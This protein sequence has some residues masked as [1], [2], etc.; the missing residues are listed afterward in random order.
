MS[1]SLNPRPVTERGSRSLATLDLPHRAIETASMRFRERTVDP[2]RQ[3]D[4]DSRPMVER[5]QLVR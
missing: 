4:R 3:H 2:Q 1:G 5:V